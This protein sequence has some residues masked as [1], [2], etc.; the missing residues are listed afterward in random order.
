VRLELVARLRRELDSHTHSILPNVDG[1]ACWNC[2]SLLFAREVKC[3]ICGTLRSHQFSFKTLIIVSA[4]A[5][6]M[7]PFVLWVASEHR[8]A[9]T[10]LCLLLLYGL[11]AILTSRETV[12]ALKLRRAPIIKERPIGQQADPPSAEEVRC[13]AC[14][15]LLFPGETT[16]AICARPKRTHFSLVDPLGMTIIAGIV[17]SIVIFAGAKVLGAALIL[18]NLIAWA[19]QFLS[20]RAVLKKFRMASANSTNQ[21]PESEPKS[22]PAP[23]PDRGARR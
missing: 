22:S 9:A 7:V 10:L 14:R 20:Y 2:K 5:S 16:C 23:G 15:A 13:G 4:A 19:W 1:A 3:A 6:L 12:A 17:V 11:Y 21:A 18:M 8:T